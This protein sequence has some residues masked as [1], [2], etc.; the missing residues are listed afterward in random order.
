MGY[1]HFE[2]ASFLDSELGGRDCIAAVGGGCRAVCH[3]RRTA[4]S[5]CCVSLP[6]ACG[7]SL[8]LPVVVCSLYA[9][10]YLRCARCGVPR[11]LLAPIRSLVRA[12]RALTRQMQTRTNVVDRTGLLQTSAWQNHHG[13]IPS[14]LCARMRASSSDRPSPSRSRSSISSKR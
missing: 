6:A 8:L 9:A 7:L 1:Q 14:V 4:G 12:H 3:R 10:V 2:S 11:S 5:L 13:G